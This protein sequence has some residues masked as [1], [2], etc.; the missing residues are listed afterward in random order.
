MKLEEIIKNVSTQYEA[1]LKQVNQLVEGLEKAKA[2][3]QQLIGAYQLAVGLKEE[4]DKEAQELAEKAK[5]IQE[6]NVVDPE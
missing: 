2:E 6:V 1:K 4:E 3:L 5:P